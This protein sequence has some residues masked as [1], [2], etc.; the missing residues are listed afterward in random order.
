MKLGILFNSAVIGKI[1]L[2]NWLI[3]SLYDIS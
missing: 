3:N 1:D 2:Y